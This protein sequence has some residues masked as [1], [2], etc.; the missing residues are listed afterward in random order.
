MASYGIL[1]R[2]DLVRTDIPE[3][4]SAFIIRVPR[5]GELRTTLAVISNLLY[6]VTSKHVIVL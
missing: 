6:L 5:I 4:H 1:R 3:E 2:V